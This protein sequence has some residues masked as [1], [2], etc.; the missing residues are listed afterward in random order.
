LDFA[1]RD[2]RLF[3]ISSELYHPTHQQPLYQNTIKTTY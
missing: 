1:R 2:S 3:R